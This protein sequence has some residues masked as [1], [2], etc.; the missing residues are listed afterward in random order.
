MRLIAGLG[1]PGTSYAATRHNIGFTILNRLAELHSVS[2]K[3]GF[4]GEY[5]QITVKDSGCFLL[6]PMTYMNNSGES[7]GALC[8]YYKI[9]PADMLLIHDELDL[10]YGS[11]KFSI[12]GSGGGHNGVD[13]VI[14]HLGARDFCRLR[15]G[16]AGISRAEM[17]GYTKDYVLA[18]FTAE[19]RESLG[20]F[21]AL[22]A[23]AAAFTAENGVRKAMEKYNG[24]INR[25]QT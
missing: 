20:G 16:V 3:D 8:G 13:S 23:E 22:G 10:P 15:M 5:A 24:K 11:I 21:T 25:R 1:N 18:A 9:K 17:R 2:W 7:V 14:S 12:N 6:K 4:R 19:E